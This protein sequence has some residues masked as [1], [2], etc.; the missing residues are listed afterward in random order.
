MMR[1]I[2]AP[3]PVEPQKLPVKLRMALRELPVGLR[4][5][6]R[7]LP[8]RLRMILREMLPDLLQNLIKKA[9][10]EKR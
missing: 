6:L 5:A 8:V 10:K 7:K 2:K 9:H 3:L 4:T 1:E